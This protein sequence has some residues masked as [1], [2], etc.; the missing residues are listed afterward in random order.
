[1]P[2][3]IDI[4]LL[5]TIARTVC[6]LLTTFNHNVISFLLYKIVDFLL[7]GCL[8]VDTRKGVSEQFLYLGP[9]DRFHATRR[10]SIRPSTNK[11]QLQEMTV[12]IRS[13]R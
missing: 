11:R 5:L 13:D 1:M 9:V 2:V 4:M 12:D 3:A 7:D 10:S 8:L 6:L